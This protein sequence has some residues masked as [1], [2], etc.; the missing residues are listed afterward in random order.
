MLVITRPLSE[1]LALQERLERLGF[2]CLRQPLLQIRFLPNADLTA[3][4]H[5]QAILA[6]SA[7]GVRALAH[8]REY[9]R[10]AAPLLAI[11]ATT[12]HTAWAESFAPVLRANGTAESLL[13]LANRHCRKS[14]RPL[15][16]ICGRHLSV[17]IA[18]RLRERGFAAHRLVLY[19]AAAA[20]RLEAKTLTALHNG[21]AHGVLFYSRRTAQIWSDLLRAAGLEHACRAMTAYCLAPSAAESAAALPFRAIHTAAHPHEDALLSL[22][23]NH[24][25]DEMLAES[26][27]PR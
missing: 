17:D 8:H 2:A 4:A 14:G 24:A 15:L 13:A 7:N 26:C 21:R 20:T 12:A 25:A 23:P 10:R 18:A 6:T 5:P 1:A 16:H 22:L 3:A 11:G 27:N 9:P 19:E